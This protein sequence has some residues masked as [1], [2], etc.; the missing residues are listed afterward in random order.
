MKNLYTAR[1]SKSPAFWVFPS[2]IYFNLV[3]DF[4]FF[5]V[6]L[7]VWISSMVGN[8]RPFLFVFLLSSFLVFSSLSLGMR[9]EY[10]M[11]D[12]RNTWG[13]IIF[14]EKENSL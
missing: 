12:E 1:T 8:L 13:K 7:L 9:T 5:S 4:L 3:L 14:I 10:P 2:V 6:I 11:I